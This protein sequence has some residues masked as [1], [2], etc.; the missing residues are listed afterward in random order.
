MRACSHSPATALHLDPRVL[1]PTLQHP[2][3]P[4]RV[5]AV[6][7]G[8]VGVPVPA[9]PHLHLEPHPAEV[10]LTVVAAVRSALVREERV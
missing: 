1:A 6:A 4:L 9:V 2:N 10:A 3:Y 8:A 7:V 5:V